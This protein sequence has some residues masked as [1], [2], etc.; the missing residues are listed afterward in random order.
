MD[1]ISTRLR[2]RT[3]E[4][5][6]LRI[7]ERLLDIGDSIVAGIFIRDWE[8]RIEACSERNLKLRLEL[9]KER[10]LSI[11]AHEAVHGFLSLLNRNAREIVSYER[12]IG[13]EGKI[14]IYAK[15]DEGQV[16]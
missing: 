6:A 13:F 16:A 3:S 12:H 8:E 2:R 4:R 15:L 11:L 9:A 10:L 5:D 14:S 1:Q 7:I